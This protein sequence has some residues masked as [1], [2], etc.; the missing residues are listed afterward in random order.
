MAYFYESTSPGPLP[1]LPKN[2]WTAS[3][4]A[5]QDPAANRQVSTPGSSKFWT[6]STPMACVRMS[7]FRQISRWR[8]QVK[9]FFALLALCV[10]NSPVIDEFPSQ[11]P[12]ARSFDVFFDPRLNKR[13]S[14]PSWGWWFETPSYSLWR[15]CNVCGTLCSLMD[16]S[17][18]NKNVL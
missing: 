3:Q 10:G 8:H 17:V 1:E 14:K 18:Y 6:S 5:S 15:H 11:R 9:T 2:R 12:V 4:A 16:T 7:A 13:L